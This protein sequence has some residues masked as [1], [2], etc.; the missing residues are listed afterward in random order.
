MIVD[1]DRE[2]LLGVVLADDVVVEDLADLFWGR[3]TVTRFRQ[4]GRLLLTDYVHAQFDALV[5]DKYGRPRNE[6]A[7]LALALAA[8]RAVERVLRAVADLA[9][10]RVPRCE[11]SQS[12]RRINQAR[13]RSYSLR[14][15][16]PAVLLPLEEPSALRRL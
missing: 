16:R 9:H 8:E 15:D 6:L 1:G 10:F 5:A 4:R 14:A 13:A 7:Y 11:P 3:D 12:P 2:Y